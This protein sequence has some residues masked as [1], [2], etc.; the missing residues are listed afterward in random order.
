ME[1]TVLGEIFDLGILLGDLIL[2]YGIL[3]HLL[4][5][6]KRRGIQEDR[7]ERMDIL[8][9]LIEPLHRDIHCIE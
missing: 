5:K 1:F 2:F 6:K 7:E 4:D 3:R 8:L 9:D